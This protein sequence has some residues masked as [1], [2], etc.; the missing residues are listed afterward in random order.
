MIQASVGYHCP[1][2]V[3][4]DNQG[5]RQPR[6]V[7]WTQPGRGQITPVVATLIAINV[8]IFL[9]TSSRPD[10]ELRFA[11]IPFRIAGGQYYRLITAA[12]LHANFFHILF[13]MFALL[14]LGPP[15]ETA[16]GRVRFLGLYLMAALGGSVCSYLFSSPNVAGVGASGAIF[17]VFGAYFVLARARRAETGGIVA[18]I[19]INLLFS[20]IDRAIDW[21]AHVG[22][23]VTGLVIGGVYALAERRPRAQRLAIE[24]ATFAALAALML[25]LIHFRTD[26]LRVP[27]A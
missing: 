17:G 10:I 14:I 6:P 8:I 11:Q 13:N 24:V 15:V 19:A 1:T 23:L 22:G 9:V 7:R 2:C 5:V 21:R 18:L 12:F 26:Q 25:G 20:F 16:V 3:K 4:E 27:V